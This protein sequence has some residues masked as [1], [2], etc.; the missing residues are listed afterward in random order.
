MS[1]TSPCAQ[2]AST[3]RSHHL[4]RSLCP[5]L[6]LSAISQPAI[7]ASPGPFPP[8]AR[9]TSKCIHAPLVLSLRMPRLLL[10]VYL[11]VSFPLIP[12][13]FRTHL[14]LLPGHLVPRHAA[15]LL[16]FS[17][18]SFYTLCCCLSHSSHT[19]SL[20]IPPPLRRLSLLSRYC[21]SLLSHRPPLA[22]AAAPPPPSPIISSGV[23]PSIPHEYPSSLHPLLPLVIL[24]SLLPQGVRSL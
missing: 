3:N 18:L 6:P 17:T 23:T 7:L 14:F 9:R 4:S 15:P 24:S 8:H 21:A 12:G 11:L 16:L 10:T 20:R 19:C 5:S 2:I 22:P 13:A 1:H